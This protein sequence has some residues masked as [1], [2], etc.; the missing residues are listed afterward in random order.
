VQAHPL[1]ADSVNTIGKDQEG[2][3]CC[4]LH[5]PMQADTHTQQ[6]TWRTKEEERLFSGEQVVGRFLFIARF[7]RFT[8][9]GLQSRSATARLDFSLTEEQNHDLFAA[10]YSACS[11][12]LFDQL[13]HPQIT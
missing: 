4:G 6:P 2:M 13:L 7:T 12:H 1:S 11:S 8:N 10:A 5:H 9:K 3:L